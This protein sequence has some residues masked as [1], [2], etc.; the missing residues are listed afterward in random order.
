MVRGYIMGLLKVDS[1]WT[2]F[3]EVYIFDLI[4]ERF[5]RIGHKEIGTGAQRKCN[6]FRSSEWL[7][8]PSMS[9]TE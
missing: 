4:E 8:S 5:D 2:N 1:L 9:L 7:S 6:L 3:E